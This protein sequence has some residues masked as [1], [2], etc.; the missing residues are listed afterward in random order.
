MNR[1]CLILLI[2]MLNGGCLIYAQESKKDKIKELLVLTHQD[3]FAIKKFENMSNPPSEGYVEYLNDSNFSKVI[4]TYITD[5][6]LL[7]SMM[8]IMKDT[9]YLSLLGSINNIYRSKAKANSS[10]IRKIAAA[11]IDV[12]MVDIYDKKFSTD[13]IDEL[14]RFYKTS[15]G[16]KSLFLLP[17]IQNELTKAIEAKYTTYLLGQS[18]R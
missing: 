12:E 14:T 6:S 5:T 3:S 8:T 2:V 9:A 15:A 10:E 4:S 13:E 7:N 1:R 17:V 11:F 16:Q 18:S